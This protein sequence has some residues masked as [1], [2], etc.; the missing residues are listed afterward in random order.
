MKKKISIWLTLLL[1]AVSVVATLAAVRLSAPRAVYG[2]EEKLAEALYVIDRYFIG[3]SDPDALADSAVDAM[4]QSLGDRWSYYMTA[5]ELADYLVAMENAYDGLGIVISAAEEGGIR[6]QSVYSRSPAGEAGVLPGSRFLRVGETDL[7]EATLDEATLKIREAIAT[8]SVELEMLLPDGTRQSYVLTPGSVLMDPVRYELL[9]SGLGLVRIANFDSHCS[10]RSIAAIEELR[11][12]GAWGLVFDVR[13][14]PGGM[15]SELLALLN[16][17]LPEGPLFH[18][19]DTEGVKTTDYSDPECLQLPM[20]VLV[21]ADSYSA[22]EFF[23]AALEEYDWAVTVGEQTSGKGYAQTIRQLT[24]GSALYLSG[25]RY[26]TPQGVSLA[27]VGLMPQLQVELEYEDWVRLYNDD[28]PPE[29][30]AQLQAAVEFLQAQ[31]G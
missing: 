13:L 11:A 16:Y 30:D 2:P 18:S 20:A 25:F 28:L 3:E 17:L 4:V 19:E 9:D 26:T 15:L 7:R 1:M 27:D 22:A 29:E 31:Q 14:N 6:V 23:A 8:G 12:Q 24:D 5:E 10:E 21:N